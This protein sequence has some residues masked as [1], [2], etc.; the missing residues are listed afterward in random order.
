MI[1]VFLVIIV[2]A[3]RM[4]KNKASSAVEVWLT[5]EE[6]IDEAAR[7]MVREGFTISYRGNTT[8]SFSR[9]IGPNILLGVVLL[10][11]FI[12]P[13]ILYLILARPTRNATAIATE[14]P[15]GTQL[16]VSGND[17]E[18]CDKLHRWASVNVASVN[19]S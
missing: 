2:V 15:A 14:G 8:V 5:P 9:Q 19:Q 1:G 7:Y 3:D 16:I 4:S 17:R 18:A 10:L 12:L 6:A 13:G 11:L